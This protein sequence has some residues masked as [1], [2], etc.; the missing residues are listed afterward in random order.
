MVVNPDMLGNME[1][2]EG[3]TRFVLGSIEAS[4]MKG[5]EPEGNMLGLGAFSG[6]RATM[7]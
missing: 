1:S 4:A 7:Y 6:V 5:I 2:S 3:I